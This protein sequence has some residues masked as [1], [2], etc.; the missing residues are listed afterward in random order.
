MVTEFSFRAIGLRGAH[1]LLGAA[2]L[3]G[4]SAALEAKDLYVSTSGN[5][6]VTYAANSA[7]Q[8]WRTIRR[9]A[10]LA[11]AGDVV[12]VAA[13][14]YATVGSG[15]R[16]TPAYNPTNNGLPSAPITFQAE[17]TV[18]LTLSSGNGSVIGANARNYITWRGFTIDERQAPSRSDTGPVTLWFCNGCVLENLHIIGDPAEAARQDNHTGIR[19]EWSTNIVIRNNLIQ[20]I[21]TGHNVNNAAGIMTYDSGSGII[22]NNEIRNVGAGVFLKGNDDPSTLGGWTIRYNRIDGARG[23]AFALHINPASQY[24]DV[25][26]NLVTNSASCVSIWG[27]D[28]SSAVAQMRRI[29]FS[30]NTCAGNQRGVYEANNMLAGVE[31]QFTNNIFTSTVANIYTLSGIETFEPSRQNFQ[32]NFYGPAPVLAN[33][34]AEG[35]STVISNFAAWRSRFSGF[36][37][38]GGGGDPLFVGGGNYRLQGSSA[39]RGKGAYIVGT[40]TIGR[41]SGPNVQPTLPS[42]PTGLRIV[43]GN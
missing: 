3:M 10:D 31:H 38:A 22:E 17:G 16:A 34:N 11:V 24:T 35:Q 37:S 33:I 19:S 1:V 9:A 43:P 18:Y 21:F 12:H 8:P 20:D 29:R 4:R 39:A 26:Q 41:F 30:N 15:S 14:T 23:G 36:D 13:G 28:P 40:E 6:S 42:T 25:A 27:L 32:G 7:S 2:L 5:D